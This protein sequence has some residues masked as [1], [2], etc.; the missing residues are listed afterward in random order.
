MSG[1]RLSGN[2]EK[3]AVE[4][5]LK[6]LENCYEMGFYFDEKEA[7]KVFAFFTLLKLFEGEWAG[8]EFY[9]VRLAMFHYMVCF[10]M[11]KV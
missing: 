5:H 11:E 4:R 6:D 10:R 9:P 8:K 3:K 7:K 2:L 1:E